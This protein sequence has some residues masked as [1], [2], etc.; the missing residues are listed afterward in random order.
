[1]KLRSSFTSLQII[2][3]ETRSYRYY[4]TS[5]LCNDLVKFMLISELNERNCHTVVYQNKCL[6]V[7]A[8]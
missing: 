5:F 4:V 8:K 1:M 3:M 6:S 7:K 2:L